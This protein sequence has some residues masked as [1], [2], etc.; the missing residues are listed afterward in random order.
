MV[1]SE[2]CGC[3]F[4]LKKNGLRSFHFQSKASYMLTFNVL[5]SQSEVTYVLTLNVLTPRVFS[6]FLSM[7]GWNPFVYPAVIVKSGI[8]LIALLSQK[9]GETE[10]LLC[11]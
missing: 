7:G 4:D 1:M 3:L 9:S 5:N 8:R 6:K 2:N 11:S 10:F